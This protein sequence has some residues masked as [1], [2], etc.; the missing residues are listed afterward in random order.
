MTAGGKPKVLCP[1]WPSQR[2]NG[3]E[4]E[5][6]AA[7]ISQSK[8]PNLS[9]GSNTLISADPMDIERRKSVISAPLLNKGSGEG[10]LFPPRFSSN[11]PGES[12]EPGIS[13]SGAGEME[14]IEL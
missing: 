9:I 7:E 10:V 3:G 1:I 4:S 8:T 5:A 6:S 12:S 2:L 11:Q 13:P 14:D